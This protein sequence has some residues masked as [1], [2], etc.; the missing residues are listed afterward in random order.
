M[1]FSG[2]SFWN[3]PSFSGEPQIAEAKRLISL[4]IVF[5]SSSI[6]IGVFAWRASA[7]FLCSLILA[8]TG[9]SE[10]IS[11]SLRLYSCFGLRILFTTIPSI[12]VFCSFAIL[13]AFSVVV[14][15]T[16]SGD[17]TK[18]ILSAAAIT[19]FSSS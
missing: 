6:V 8:K 16:L 19:G 14:S 15:V 18:N 17:V 5:V 7:I 12:G 11:I 4:E 13:A 9:I 3:H 10:M 1:S 2:I